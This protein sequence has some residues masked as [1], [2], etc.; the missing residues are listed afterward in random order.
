MAQELDVSNHA[1]ETL[2]DAPAAGPAK[3]SVHSFKYGALESDMGG[4]TNNS[5]GRN[6]RR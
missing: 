4:R 6:M 2:P 1:T 3:Q 5:A